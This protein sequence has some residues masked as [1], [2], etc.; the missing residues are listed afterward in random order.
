MDKNN[1]IMSFTIDK[2]FA[3]DHFLKLR[4]RV[5]HDGESPNK[6]YFTKVSESFL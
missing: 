5:C 3:S 1:F 4:L 6:T 2:D